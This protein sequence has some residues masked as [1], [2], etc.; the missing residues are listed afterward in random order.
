MNVEAVRHQLHIANKILG[1]NLDGI[2]HEESMQLQPSGA[3]CVNWIVGHVVRARTEA[4]ECLG[5]ESPVSRATLDA[6]RPAQPW[7]PDGALSLDTLIA[8]LDSLRDALDAGLA[9]LTPE[10]AA[11]KAPFSPTNNPDETL[12]SLMAVFLFHES[13]HVGQ[14]GVLRRLLGKAGVLA[15]PASSLDD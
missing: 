12:G 15:A 8:H 1:V 3:S 2:S 7:N 4:V 5:H 9:G 11:T 10:G 14:V 13:Y 6:Y